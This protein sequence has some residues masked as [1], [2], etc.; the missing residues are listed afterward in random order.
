MKKYAISFLLLILLVPHLY[1]QDESTHD[2]LSVVLFPFHNNT[3]Q[4]DYV[5]LSNVIYNGIYEQIN[6]SSQIL[7][8]QEIQPH[9]DRMLSNN[10]GVMLEDVLQDAKDQGVDYIIEGSYWIFN[11]QLVSQAKVYSVSE[12]EYLPAIENKLTI[13]DDIAATASSLSQSQA[14]I[15]LAKLITRSPEEPP[16]QEQRPLILRPPNYENP[17][18][19]RQYDKSA[20]GA[21]FL[22]FFIGY[23]SG[24]FYGELYIE[25]ALF[26][27]LDIAFSITMI[28]SFVHRLENLFEREKSPL[29]SAFPYLMIAGAVSHA[30]QS[31]SAPVQIHL[32]NKAEEERLLRLRQAHINWDWN[33]GIVDGFN[34][35]L[36]PRNFQEAME[37]HIQPSY[38]FRF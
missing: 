1:A 18:F 30:V 4:Q 20:I 38:S 26:C 13:S 9:I 27:A 15:V 7:F 28:V 33:D 32:K 29:E 34:L 5:Y 16:E 8:H 36:G 31:I 17:L 24:H 6:Q 10:T 35:E 37:L 12:D 22:S 23:G 2:P 14:E 25:G 19:E 21:F 3:Y 11:N